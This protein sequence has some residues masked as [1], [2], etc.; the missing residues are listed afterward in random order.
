MNAPTDIHLT[1]AKRVLRYIR[2]TLDHGL[3]Y[4]PGPISLSTFFDADWAGDPNDRRST[5]GLLVYLGTTPSP[6][7]L[8]NNLQF[9]VHPQRLSTEHLLLPQLNYV[10]FVL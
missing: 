3:F 6:G 10:G 8:R 4:T 9:L 1:A 7:L 5:S 2:G